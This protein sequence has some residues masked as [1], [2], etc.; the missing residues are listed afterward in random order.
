MFASAVEYLEEPP[1]PSPDCLLLD[2][3]LPTMD[4][5]EL[6]ERLHETGPAPPI[7]F[8]SGRAEEAETARAKSRSVLLLHK[9]FS[10]DALF[11]AI[12]DAMTS[13]PNGK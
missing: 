13:V 9:P 8:I 1:R 12:H 5:F 10:D 3:G 2:I 4:G 11:V 7:V 6:E